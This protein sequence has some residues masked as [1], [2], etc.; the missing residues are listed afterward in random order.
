MKVIRAYSVA[1]T[2]IAGLLLLFTL[3]ACGE[4]EPRVVVRE[5]RPTPTSSDPTS[6]P[7]PT[8]TPT[9]TAAP[10]PTPT[11]TP[12]LTP[13]PV[14]SPSPTMESVV[15]Q[16]AS[17]ITAGALHTCMLDA[18]GKATCWG[19]ETDTSV[20]TLLKGQLFAAFRF[21]TVSSN[22]PH[23]CGLLG[24]GLP[25]D[26]FP[27]CAGNAAVEAPNDPDREPAP[28]FA[29]ISSGGSH[30]CVLTPSGAVGCWGGDAETGQATPPEDVGALKA[31]SSGALHTCALKTDGSAVCWGTGE[32]ASEEPEGMFSAIAS[33][34]THTCALKAD[35]GKPQCW[36]TG[37][38][39]MEAPNE[40][41]TAIASGQT[42]SCGLKADGAP[43][44]WGDNTDNR[45]TPPDDVGA[46]TAIACGG[47]H[48]CGLKADG[49][50]VCWGANGNGQAT[51][52]AAPS[53]ADPATGAD[54]TQTPPTPA[55]SPAP[56]TAP[57]SPAPAAQTPA[58]AAPGAGLPAPAN[59]TATP[60]AS[61]SSGAIDL[62]WETVAGAASYRVTYGIAGDA[63][64]LDTQERTGVVFTIGGLRAGTAYWVA[65]AAVGSDGVAGTEDRREDVMPSAA[66]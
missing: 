25:T 31:I 6:T 17:R 37:A 45:A 42:H 63:T 62:S 46:L 52:P 22:G 26:G 1:G 23:F 7:T 54:A 57:P 55:P 32:A 51:P 14:P 49:S 64:I 39:T 9:P 20:V 60:S 4:G 21:Q 11:A 34:G 3:A 15:T 56:G 43:V 61:V 33:G 13:T 48:T 47:A 24:G 41:L 2:L 19:E 59:F 50:V 29:A 40:A 8:P 18:E 38:A 65:I 44:C 28:P 53:T 36:G 30:V 12:T 35:D 58:P 16:A 66:Q 27:F 5:A 10:T